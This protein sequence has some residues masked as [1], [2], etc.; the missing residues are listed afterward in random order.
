M[1]KPTIFFSHSSK[2]R[3]LILPIK[4]KLT[5]I[6]SGIM[7]IFMSSDGQSIPF[8]R[9]WVSKIEEGLENA[10]IMFVFVTPNS[11]RSDWIYF[12]AGYAYS[13]KIDVIP[14]GIGVN[15]GE[16]NAPLNLLQGFDV[17]SYDSLNNFISIINKK[18]ALSFKEEFNETDYTMISRIIFDEEADFN[19]WKVFEGGYYQCNS[20]YVENDDKSE[21]N[22]LDIAKY[23]N[24]IKN[25]LEKNR[26]QYSS[27]DRE[28]LVNG[29][30]IS[31]KFRENEP[32]KNSENQA[33]SLVFHLSTYNFKES[34]R[35]LI[36]F[37]KV[38]NSGFLT[39][40]LKINETYNCLYSGAEISSII[41]STILSTDELSYSKDQVG[42]FK[43]K[44]KISWRISLS[45]SLAQPPYT[46]LHF[47]FKLNETDINEVIDFVNC[48]C[49]VGI[50]YKRE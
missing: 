10:H 19:F 12:E 45:N 15:I 24:D 40:E 42:V 35:L 16:L 8:G 46:S 41:S 39:L 36:K 43:Y 21:K 11:I 49:K 44:D 33:Y 23:Y 9:N 5:D 6:T 50:I 14:V 7:D 17:L 26:I 1:D 25:Y 22:K 37:F 20:Q 47:S 3:D 27:S 31:I 28:I 4:N 29:I 38:M 34:L 2:D 48:L 32:K 18:F 30:R 13:K